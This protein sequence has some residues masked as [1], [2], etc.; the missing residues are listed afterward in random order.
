M[1]EVSHVLINAASEDY[2]LI[3]ILNGPVRVTN[4]EHACSASI[5]VHTLIALEVIFQSNSSHE[6]KVCD[7]EQ[8][9][10]LQLIYSGHILEGF[11]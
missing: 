3:S 1:R 6:S 4:R 11:S 9:S 8:S 10:S 7:C 5:C 2:V